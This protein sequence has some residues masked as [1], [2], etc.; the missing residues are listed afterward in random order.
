MLYKV[1][2]TCCS[3]DIIKKRKV[4]II[5]KKK[6]LCFLFAIMILMTSCPKSK[7][8]LVLDK[9]GD[10]VNIYNSSIVTVMEAIGMSSS[11]ARMV[12]NDIKLMYLG[13]DS[14]SSS[15]GCFTLQYYGGL[16][17]V[18]ADIS[19]KTTYANIPIFV[20]AYAIGITDSGTNLETLLEWV[21]GNWEL[22][23]VYYSKNYIIIAS[24]EDN[25]SITLLIMPS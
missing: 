4:C 15:D 13:N 11:L 22:E 24:I 19:E 8:E 23:P 25:V 6:I 7:A 9:N 21:N 10:L 18:S 3:M 16:I 1:Y 20:L 12:S 2:E 14:Y 17:L 5:M